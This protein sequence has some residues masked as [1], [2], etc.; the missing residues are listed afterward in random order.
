[1]TLIWS[2]EC[3]D[4]DRPANSKRLA[5]KIPVRLEGQHTSVYAKDLVVDDHAQGKKVKHVREIVP[6]IRIP[7]FP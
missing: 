6:D 7:I 1:M 4:G 3:I 5:G 2:I